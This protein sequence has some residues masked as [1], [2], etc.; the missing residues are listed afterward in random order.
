MP[1]LGEGFGQTVEDATRGAVKVLNA[2]RANYLKYLDDR[3]KALEAGSAFNE[4]KELT[5]RGLLDPDEQVLESLVIQ[6]EY[7]SAFDQTVGGKGE[8]AIA[9][10]PAQVSVGGTLEERRTSNANLRIT[11]TFVGRDRAEFLKRLPLTA[12]VIE[13]AG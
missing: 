9:V 12:N 1:S 13:H 2:Q 11:A 7:A 6:A 4:I 5:D 10:G 8:L 3:S